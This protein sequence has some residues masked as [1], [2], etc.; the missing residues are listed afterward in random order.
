MLHSQ[1]KLVA[2]PLLDTHVHLGF[3]STCQTIDYLLKPEHGEQL[4]MITMF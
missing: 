4:T 2:A 3:S 1:E